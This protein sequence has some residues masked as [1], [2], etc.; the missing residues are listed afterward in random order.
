MKLKACIEYLDAM[1]PGN[2]IANT[3]CNVSTVRCSIQ[4]DSTSCGVLALEYTRRLLIG[5]SLVNINTSKACILQLCH[6]M[7]QELRVGHLTGVEQVAIPLAEESPLQSP[8]S[9]VQ[10]PSAATQS[11]SMAGQTPFPGA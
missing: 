9:A 1:Y 5:E 7:T 2:D 8:P 11:R 4:K 10:I 6:R 3:W